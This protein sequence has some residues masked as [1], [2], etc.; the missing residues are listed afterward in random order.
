MVKLVAVRKF[1]DL[2]RLSYGRPVILLDHWSQ[3]ES[4]CRAH[5][6]I[7]PEEHC[8]KSLGIDLARKTFPSSMQSVGSGSTSV[9]CIVEVLN[10]SLTCRLKTLSP[11]DVVEPKEEV[12]RSGVQAFI[13]GGYFG[14]VLPSI[15]G[16]VPDCAVHAHR[17]V[18]GACPLVI[19]L[20]G[21]T[22]INP[23]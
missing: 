6:V 1:T 19:L 20:V 22:S 3:S 23:K 18:V 11:G 12:I 2:A 5:L 9:V 8:S 14:R 16:T 13:H 7:Q 10:H 15:A 4:T 17:V 21:D